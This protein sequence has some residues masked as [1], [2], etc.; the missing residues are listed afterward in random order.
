MYRH[1]QMLSREFPHE[2][3]DSFFRVDQRIQG[4]HIRSCYRLG[5]QGRSGFVQAIKKYN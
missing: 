5:L 2:F 3:Y 4:V 1:E